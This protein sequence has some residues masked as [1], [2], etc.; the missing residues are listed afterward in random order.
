MVV[1]MVGV[2]K[3]Q[4]K[5]QGKSH[6]WQTPGKGHVPLLLNPHESSEYK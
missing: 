2:L 6:N 5:R 3:T 4:G 1:V